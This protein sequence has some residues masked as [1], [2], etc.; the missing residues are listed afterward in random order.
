MPVTG[1]HVENVSYPDVEAHDNTFGDSSQY[2]CTDC[3]QTSVSTDHVGGTLDLADTFNF[4]STDKTIN[5]GAAADTTD[6]TCAANCHADNN[7][8]QRQWSKAAFS[9]ATDVGDARCE[10]CH[11][12]LNSWR[13]G[14]SVDHNKAKVNDGTHADCTVCHVYPDSPYVWATHHDTTPTHEVQYN[15]NAGLTYNAT[16]GTCDSACHDDTKVMGASTIF[17]ESGLIGTGATCSTCHNYVNDADHSEDEFG[18]ASNSATGWATTPT[19]STGNWN[20]HQEHINTGLVEC[21]DCHGHQGSTIEHNEGRDATASTTVDPAFVNID[22]NT[23]FNLGGTATYLGSP[24]TPG[25]P[26]RCDNISCHYGL[27]PDW[28]MRNFAAPAGTVTPSAGPVIT[29]TT[30]DDDTT[31]NVIDALTFTHTGG[32]VTL[33]NFR[34]SESGTAVPTTDITQV[35]MWISAD[36]M[37]DV[38]DTLIGTGMWK[39]AYFE[40]ASQINFTITG[41]KNVLVTADVPSGATHNNTIVLSLDLLQASWGNIGAGLPLASD[42][43]TI[44]NPVTLTSVVITS[45]QGST[46]PLANFTSRVGDPTTQLYATGINSDASTVNLTLSATWTPS[47]GNTLTVN[48]SGVVTYN[49][50]NNGGTV[51][52]TAD[53]GSGITDTVDITVENIT[54]MTIA[55]SSLSTTPSTYTAGTYPDSHTFFATATWSGSAG[56]ALNTDETSSAAWSFDQ[57]QSG[58]PA[59]TNGSYTLGETSGTDIIRATRYTAFD[60]QSV[61]VTGKT[62]TSVVITDTQGSQ[63]PLANFTDRVGDP[64]VQ[65]YATGTY[66]DATTADLTL[67]VTWSPSTGNT[68]TVSA[69]GVVT[70]NTSNNGG[71]VVVSADPGTV[72]PDTVDITVENIQV[73]RVSDTAGVATTTIYTD[74]SDGGT[75]TFHSVATW[76][77]SSGG[78]LNT[79]EDGND[80]WSSVALPSG[81]SINTTSGLYTAGSGT[82]VDDIIYTTVYTLDSGNHS[83]RVNSLTSVVI[84]DTRG[85]SVELANFAGR[86][87]YANVP[88]FATGT[89]SDGNTVDLTDDGTFTWSS[90]ATTTA[91]VSSAG[92]LSYNTLNNGNGGTPVVITFSDGTTS[93]TVSVTVEY[94][95]NL[96]V[97]DTSSNTTPSSWGTANPSDTHQFYATAEWSGTASGGASPTDEEADN[98][99]YT[100]WTPASPPSG[101]SLT[102]AGFYTAGSTPTDD[103]ITA[104]VFTNASDTQTVTVSAASA[105]LSNGQFTSNANS[106]TWTQTVADTGASNGHDGAVGSNYTTSPFPGSG[107]GSY[108]VQNGGNSRGEYAGYIESVALASDI[109][110]GTAD[111]AVAYQITASGAPSQSNDMSI[112]IDF[113]G[114]DG[115]SNVGTAS[116]ANLQNTTGVTWTGVTGSATLSSTARYVRI[117][118]SVTTNNNQSSV[119][120]V[121]VDDIGVAASG[122]VLFAPP[123][124]TSGDQGTACNT[125]HQF[126]PMDDDDYTGSSGGSNGTPDVDESASPRYDTEYSY[127]SPGD[128]D[129]HGVADLAI[130]NPDELDTVGVCDVCHPDATGYANN[131]MDLAKSLDSGS[132][133]YVGG[134]GAGSWGGTTCTN[135]N[136]HNWTETPVWGVGNTSCT[137][138]HALPPDTNAHTEHYTAKGWTTGL[139]D[140]CTV[141][142]P[143]NEAG[144]HSSIDGTPEVGGT[145]GISFTNPNCTS[146]FGGLGCHATG[147]STNRN[148]TD[149]S[150]TCTDCHT[151]T[152]TSG[153]NPTSGLHS[154]T[155]TISEQRH[156]SSISGGCEACHTPNASDHQDGTFEGNGIVAGDRT[157]MGISSFWTQGASDNTGTCLTTGCHTTLSDAWVHRWDYTDTTAGSCLG[158]HGD[159]TNSWNVGV[160]HNYATTTRTKHGTGSTWECEDCHALEASTNNYTLVFNAQNFTDANW[161]PDES[162][163]EHGNGTIEVNSQGNYNEGDP[164]YCTACHNAAPFDM[165]NTDWPLDTTLAGDPISVVCGE[166]HSDGVT[167]SL[168]SQTHAGHGLSF[169][170]IAADESV[171]ENC[172]PT[173]TYTNYAP[174]TGH[175]DGVKDLNGTKVTYSGSPNGTCFTASCHNQG[176]GGDDQSNQW[177]NSTQLEC[178]DCHYYEATVAGSGNNA[179]HNAS[180]SNAHNTHFDKNKQCAQC[181]TVEP[182]GDTT[183]IN[184]T[185]T[186]IDASNA[187]FGEAT[188][189]G[190]KTITYSNPNCSA[191]FGGLGCHASAPT[192]PIAWTTTSI[193]CT[194]CH[195]PQA[196]SNTY[197]PYS[198]LHDDVGTL[199]SSTPHDDSFGAGGV[200]TTCHASMASETNH[201]NGTDN[202]NTVNDLGLEADLNYNQTVGDQGSCF[203]SGNGTLT[204]CHSGAGDDG[205]WLRKWDKSVSYAN[206]GSTECAGCHGGFAGDWTFGTDNN[207]GDGAVSHDRDWDGAQSGND[208]AEVIGNHTGSTQA[209]R[210]NICHVYPDA[211]Y[212][213]TWGN[214][215][216]DGNITMNNTMG[217][218]STTNYNCSTNCHTEPG[219]DNTD[220]NLEDSGWSVNEINGPA[221]TCGSCHSDGVRPSIASTTHAMHLATPGDLVG[222]GG[223]GTWPDCVQCHPDVNYDNA[224]SGAL[225]LDAAKVTYSGSPN[226]T[227]FTA[228]CHNQG[229]GGE[230]QSNTWDNSTQLEC[231]DCHYYEGP[232]TSSSVAD[233]TNNVNHLAPLTNAHNAHFDKAK[234]CAEC[235][236][237]GSDGDTTHIDTATDLVTKSN[238]AFGEAEADVGGSK[239]ITYSSSNCTAGFGGLGC[240]A[241]GG[242]S[243]RNWTDTS[244][245]CTDCHTNTTDITVNPYTGLHD[246]TPTVSEV[247]HYNNFSYN[248]GGSTATCETCHTTSPSTRHQDATFDSSPGAAAGHTAITFAG[249]VGFTDAA[250]PTCGPSLTGCHLEQTVS[251]SWSRLWHDD[252]D[253]TSGAECSGCHGDFSAW[254]SGTMHNTLP[255]RGNSTHINT[256]SLGYSCTDC[257]VIGDGSGGYTFTIGTADWDQDAGETS[258]HGNGQITINIGGTTWSRSGGRSGCEACHDGP[259]NTGFDFVQTSWTVDQVTGDTPPVGC[260]NCHGNQANGTYWPDDSTVHLANDEPGRHALHITELATRHSYVTTNDADQKEM[261]SYCHK[262][263]NDGDFSTTHNK[264]SVQVGGASW[265]GALWDTYPTFT[266]NWTYTDATGYDGSCASVDCHNNKTTDISPSTNTSGYGWHDIDSGTCTMCHTPGGGGNDPT[267]GLHATVSGSMISGNPH[268]DSFQATI[269]EGTPSGTCETC[270]TSSPSTEH[271]NGSFANDNPIVALDTTNLGFT[272]GTPPTCAVQGAL[273]G[274]HLDADLTATGRDGGTVTQAWAR[275][276]SATADDTGTPD[277]KCYNCHGTFWSTQ[278]FTTGVVHLYTSEMESIHGSPG[279]NTDD[280]NACHAWGDA[281][282]TTTYGSGN[283]GNG[284]ITINDDGGNTYTGWSRGTAG[285]SDRSVCADCHDYPDTPRHYFDQTWADTLTDEVAGHDVTVACGLCHQDGVTPSYASTTHAAHGADEADLVAGQ[286]NWAACNPCHPDVNYDNAH[287]G[288]LQFDAAKVTYS[289]GENGT[290]FTANCHNQGSG[291]QDQSN[292]WDNSTQLECDDCHY[293][294]GPV[295]SSSVADSTNNVNHLA[296]L[297]NAHNAHFDKAKQCVLCHTVQGDGDTTHIDVATN[298]VT[299]SNADFGEATVGGSMTITY[300]NPNCTANFGGLGC[301]ASAPADQNWT[302]TSIGCTNCHVTQAASNTYD[303][304]S[305]VHDDAGTLVSS[306]PHDDSFGVGGTCTT[307]HASM[308]SETN[309]INGTDNGNTVNDLGLNADLSYSQSAGDDGSCFGSGNGTLT[310]C[311]S[312]AGDDGTWQRLWDSSVSYANDGSTECAGCHGGFAND[313]TFGTDNVDADG[314]VSHDRD[315]DGAT[316]GEVIGNHTGTVQADRCKMCHG[317]GYAGVYDSANMGAHRD[318]RITFNDEMGYNGSPNFDC[319]TYCHSDN[320]DHGLETS[321]WLTTSNTVDCPPLAC[322][323]CHGASTPAA[324]VGTGSP[325]TSQTC[326]YC[327]TGHNSGT[328]Q[329][330]NNTT[331]G[332][333]YGLGGIDLGNSLGATGA[334][335]EEICNGCHGA[336]YTPWGKTHGSY[337]TGTVS[338]NTTWSTATWSSANFSYKDGNIQST[339]YGRA[340]V[341]CSYCHDVHDTYAGSP[342]GTPFLRGDWTSNPFMEDG[343]PQSAQAGWLK[344]DAKRSENDGELPRA[345]AY[346]A[347]AANL[348]NQL[349]GWQI[350]QNNNIAFSETYSTFGELCQL[351]HAQGTLET[352]WTGHAGAVSGFSG[353][354][355][356]NFFRTGQ[357]GGNGNWNLGDMGYNTTTTSMT[358]IPMVTG[359]SNSTYIGGLRNGRDVGNGQEE[360]DGI[361]TGNQAADPETPLTSNIVYIGGAVTSITVDD[362][363]YDNN[364]HNFPCS[365]CHSPHASRLPRLMI[366]NC[367]DVNHNAWDNSEASPAGWA[368]QEPNP[369]NK[370]PPLD[371]S[372]GFVATQLSY[373]PTGHN[374]HR[375]VNTSWSTGGDSGT[376][377]SGNEGGW[378]TVTPWDDPRW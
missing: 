197:D 108:Q 195:V 244:I 246:E 243:S 254:A 358:R 164:G 7:N 174:T 45:T 323:D 69:A 39:G 227:C 128:H 129:K 252:S 19:R 162:S 373:S 25:D 140:E 141:C 46:T 91:D 40:P 281:A 231:D 321:G 175:N 293:Y 307:C 196:A 193:G 305:G 268:D 146:G 282:Y 327:H 126:G 298:L 104:T 209:T 87:G 114:T 177:D 23:A 366:T 48:S 256:G 12:Q 291:G 190:S 132:I 277:P 148:W 214:D 125:C 347:D 42:T 26:K 284:Q 356:N 286:G 32:D 178:N 372:H 95:T 144:G 376:P 363:T 247:Q 333:N 210:C 78:S 278:A 75:N 64:T 378:N 182:D 232:V 269:G 267:S 345:G 88:L 139:T 239:G 21:T 235:H 52:V 160:T 92:V 187:A 49:T 28:G 22:V 325:H 10:V 169:G 280:C 365:K 300:S 155:P 348:N 117:A 85:S 179:A 181:H 119:G 288:S 76:S 354:T 33:S 249:N 213:S 35:Q 194:D 271:I 309:H 138:C 296:P 316:P 367:L 329:I 224:H 285:N 272:D 260:N 331:V 79:D 368:P 221:L 29:G 121:W 168:T 124:Q 172:H 205:T 306:T 352:A 238:A 334:T 346:N 369:D 63:T 150:I 1:L 258:N 299:K 233:S 166:C 234:Q 255:T 245:A 24:T 118:I 336:T 264:G 143:D 218:D 335:E 137:S 364:F 186:L 289:S 253:Q 226:G 240:H 157:A 276:W 212:N 361:D 73:L 183:H 261:C 326:E 110:T 127:A 337:T 2:T 302:D 11:G 16:N 184:S 154:I 60:T 90:D 341:S 215:H 259:V 230:D 350:E 313:W 120:T 149:T 375:Y 37:W 153:Q 342:T 328:I 222:G 192:S 27:T 351:C 360:V 332:I 275:R 15:S 353:S 173:R 377:Q 167:D 165:A 314:S 83:I 189:G 241:T 217:Y 270:H 74:S 93:D 4:D 283:H 106:W 297:T 312:G 151:D 301:H 204:T 225:Q 53:A 145:K 202:G 180:L 324:G 374:C 250:I 206:D 3:H 292:T 103:V 109:P 136:C 135:V 111:W 6:D 257:H 130:N 94:I 273:V 96:T 303:P 185:T 122:G 5:V 34:V 13:A 242:S 223:A 338:N 97:A 304:Y 266:D 357:R 287:N 47:T 207:T 310:N 170:T 58:A 370:L 101:G 158:C 54:T 308:A 18:L 43:F 116:V 188:V 115:T 38:G 14:M 315:W 112:D 31:H 211:P 156:D 362:S 142:H 318:G 77:G 200:C 65:L 236:A 237:V 100:N 99:T 66:S 319:S 44:N 98:P 17:T 9:S 70:Y 56:G 203:G 71:T 263:P 67:S 72:P 86:V 51:T 81:G 89:Y 131:H 262:S 349:H 159:F 311:H 208:G 201:I 133:G 219:V 198:G 102:A 220:H 62:L 20:T 82:A 105:I 317:Y 216:G 343:A 339:H 344:V 107:A 50:N 84:T 152:T 57:N 161:N 8:W 265:S 320:T 274:C 229:S 55:D 191:N 290:C 228:N 279:D 163:S 251:E 176:S 134:T 199:V 41:T 355:N 113:I 59:I 322:G 123:T 61:V 36:N 294:E 371:L 340:G 295:T 68:L 359:G 80:A 171:C 330:P 248:S 147:G 30:V